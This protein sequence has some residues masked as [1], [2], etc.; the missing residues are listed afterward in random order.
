MRSRV[1]ASSPGLW[2]SVVGVIEAHAS[3]VVRPSSTAHTIVREA[4]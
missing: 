2:C 4:P 1:S 3:I